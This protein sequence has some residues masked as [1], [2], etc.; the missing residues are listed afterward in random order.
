MMMT[1]VCC[2]VVKQRRGEDQARSGMFPGMSGPS[3][4]TSPQT[5][6]LTL[7][8]TNT[9]YHYNNTSSSTTHTNTNTII[10]CTRTTL[11]IVPRIVD[12]YY[13]YHSSYQHHKPFTNTIN[14]ANTIIITI[15]TETLTRQISLSF[16]LSQHYHTNTTNTNQHYY[17]IRTTQVY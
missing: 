6:R 15:V 8:I 14:S 4:H 10:T 11:D 1:V 9:I 3:D 5:N 2:A 16:S 7:D 12:I 13:H 17:G